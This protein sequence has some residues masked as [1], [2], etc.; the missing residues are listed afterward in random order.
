MAPRLLL[1]FVGARHVPQQLD[2][3]AT[4]AECPIGRGNI[5]ARTGEDC[6]RAKERG[7]RFARPQAADAK[8][9]EY[10]V[11]STESRTRRL[12]AIMGISQGGYVA[13]IASSSCYGPLRDRTSGCA[14]VLT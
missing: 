5:R 8:S 11:A 3:Q 10:I 7:V 9:A 13:A 2:E 1:K 6:K 14:P 12:V 4:S